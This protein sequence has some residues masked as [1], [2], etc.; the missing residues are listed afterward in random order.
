MIDKAKKFLTITQLKNKQRVIN[1]KYKEEGLSDKVLEM[2]VELNT[3]RHEMDIPD[4]EN[5][6]FED[7]VQ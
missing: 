1:K 2:Q 3:L 7:Y 5:F 6:V 4:T